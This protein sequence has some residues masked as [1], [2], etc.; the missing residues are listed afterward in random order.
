MLYFPRKH[1]RGKIHFMQIILE[2]AISRK[3]LFYRR[4]FKTPVCVHTERLDS[5]CCFFFNTL[6]QKISTH[7]SM[8][9]LRASP[10]AN[11]NLWFTADLFPFVLNGRRSALNSILKAGRKSERERM[12]ARRGF[13]MAAVSPAGLRLSNSVWA[14]AR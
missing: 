5:I 4:S 12:R 1:S 11:G 8:C 9:F 3:D 7:K 10:V 13:P 2:P 6:C 14:T